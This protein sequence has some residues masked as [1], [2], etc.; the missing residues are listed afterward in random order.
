MAIGENRLIAAIMAAATVQSRLMADDL[1]YYYALWLMNRLPP[2]DVPKLACDALEEGLDSPALRCLAGLQRPTS[3][4]IGE[5]FDD[6][7]SQ[8]GIVPASAGATEERL[9]DE[10]IRNAT[11]VAKRISNQILDGTLDPVEGW[12]RLPYREGE[13]GP[14]SVFFEFAD[15]TGSVQF[16]DHFC[17]RLIDAAKRFQSTAQ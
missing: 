9:S 17:S 10:W 12:L 4:D 11:Q 13:L 14:L 1:A 15:P 16:D 7:C 8:L 5:L 2:E 6:A 3:S